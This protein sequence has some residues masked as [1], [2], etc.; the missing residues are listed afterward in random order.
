M[1]RPRRSL[2]LLAVGLLVA[3]SLGCAS[4]EMT[5]SR[6]FPR[7]YQ[8][9]PRSILVLPPINR[10]TA[11]EARDYYLTTVQPPLADRGFYVYPMEIISE[12]MKQEGL[13]Q[14]T[15]LTKI[16]PAK[17]REFF[18]ADAVLYVI[19]EE[20]DTTYL[21]L[22]ANVTVQLK[23]VLRSTKTGEVLWAYEDR[24]VRDTS[25]GDG[26]QDGVAGLVVQAVETAVKT[27]STQY[28]D[29]ARDVNEKSLSSLPTG[30]Y[31]PAYLKDQEVGEIDTEKI[32]EEFHDD[33]NASSSP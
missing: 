1:T 10:T 33:L 19:I 20:W 12:V 26:G 8:E 16:D 22:A 11:S 5:R 24:I 7:I 21:V 2:C 15:D 29:L 31:H 23:Y 30:P 17:F 6:A 3:L 28:V 25:G 14:N 27:A 32:P 4:K 18:G 13:Y 9:T